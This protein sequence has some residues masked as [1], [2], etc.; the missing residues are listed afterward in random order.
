MKNLWSE[1]TSQK[2]TGVDLLAYTSRLI[3]ADPELVVWGG[4]NSS[5]K[6]VEPDHLGEKIPVMYIKGS[7]SDMRTIERKHFTRLRLDDLLLLE[8]RETMT[9][10]EM[11]EY[12]GQAMMGGNQP[13]PSIETLLHAFVPHDHVYH[14]HADAVTSLTDTPDSPVL[15]SKLFGK[16]LALIPYTRPGFTLSKWVGA[17][18][19]SR[20]ELK[21][22][23]LDKHGLITWGKTAKEAYER[24]IGFCA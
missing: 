20:S 12:L 6:C 8:R 21:G 13:R 7:G 2:L 15:I 11:V 16:E 9:D 14:S 10:E 5:L 22:V 4:G 17:I 23:I 24:T 3:G 19:K 18:V 1:K